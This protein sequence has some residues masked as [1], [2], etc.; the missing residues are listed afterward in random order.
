MS[1]HKPEP[2]SQQ[3]MDELKKMGYDRSDLSMKVISWSINGFFIFTLICIA[4]SYFIYV[5]LD[6]YFISRQQDRQI[7]RVDR[8]RLPDLPNPL[9]QSNITARGDMADLRNREFRVLGEYGWIDRNQDVARIPIDRALEI[10]AGGVG[11]R[12]WTPGVTIGEP[13][14]GPGQA[15]P[16]ATPRSIPQAATPMPSPGDAGG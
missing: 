3:E 13:D 7:S 1:T 5:A 2:L 6:N 4:I 9:L 14:R 16:Q 11:Q 10:A 15:I 8:R 12:L